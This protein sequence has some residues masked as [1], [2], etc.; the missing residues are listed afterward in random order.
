MDFHV[1]EIEGPS[2]ILGIQWLH[3]LGQITHDYANQIMK[4]LWEDERIKL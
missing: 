3:E 1:L 2:V 4:F